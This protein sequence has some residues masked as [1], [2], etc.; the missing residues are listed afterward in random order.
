[1]KYEKTG[2]AIHY[3]GAFSPTDADSS[4]FE[5]T[6]ANLRGEIIRSRGKGSLRILFF[7]RRPEEAF[8]QRLT[9]FSL[10]KKIKFLPIEGYEHG[11]INLYTYHVTQSLPQPD[12]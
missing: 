3:K 1:L 12:K 9:G 11:G 10:V 2:R 6:I 4:T 5:R 8:E 7:D